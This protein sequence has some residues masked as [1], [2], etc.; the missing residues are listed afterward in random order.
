MEK[1]EISK[2]LLN[3]I[4]ELAKSKLVPYEK[5]DELVTKSGYTIKSD[6]GGDV[7]TIGNG[8]TTLRFNAVLD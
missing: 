2:C 1:E 5:I 3:F 7:T 4:T 6:Y 8:E